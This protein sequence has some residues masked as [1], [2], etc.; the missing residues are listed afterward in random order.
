[1]VRSSS[2]G[3]SSL[4]A[5]AGRLAAKTPEARNRYADF[6]RALSI[7]AVVAGHWLI[8]AAHVTGGQ[9]RLGHMLDIAPWTQW[10]SWAFQ[11]MPVFFIVGGFSNGASWNSARE[12]GRTYS[13]WLSGRL[14]RLVGPVLPLL[15]VWI[16]LGI[17]ARIGGVS[18]SMIKIGSQ[19]A[20]V[21]VWFLSVYILVV[22]IVPITHA[23]W[24]RF[25]MVS[26]WALAAATVVVDIGRFAWGLQA[27]AWINYLFV[28]SAVHQLGYAWRDGHLSGPARALAWAA[29][30]LVVLLGLVFPGPYPLS[31]VGVPGDPVSN[32]LPPSLAMLALGALQGGLLLALESPIRR[33]LARL[34]PWTA[35]VLVNGMIMTIY[36]WHL[37]VMVLIIGLGV[38]MGGMG[39]GLE[40]GSVAWWATRPVWMALLAAVLLP[41]IAMFGRFERAAGPTR[42]LPAWRSVSGAVL[43]CAGLALLA[44]DG[45][46]GTG[47]LGIGIWAALLPFVGAWLTGM[48]VKKKGDQPA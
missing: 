9:P 11:V 15:G 16:A 10:L 30:G 38:L 20:L 4:W 48:P 32:T 14:H 36:L 17:A 26:F 47:P 21:P 39:L 12:A 27:A 40:P 19:A 46:G 5:A 23:A 7:G 37:T 8:A 43:V 13:D 35:T 29:G 44:L 31:M 6:L 18:P 41:F 33:W 34:G 22:L 3:R 25:G 24:R 2:S 1:M 42:A 28:W 45:I